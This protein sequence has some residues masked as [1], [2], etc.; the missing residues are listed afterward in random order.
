ML[1]IDMQQWLIHY[2]NKALTKSV[3]FHAQEGVMDILLFTLEVCVF[4]TWFGKT[5][6]IYY[7]PE[8]VIIVQLKKQ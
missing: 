5:T 7:T 2:V 6:K 3:C 4:N 8:Y 1:I